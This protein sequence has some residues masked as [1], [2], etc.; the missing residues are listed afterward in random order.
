MAYSQA[1]LDALETAI[2][3]GVLTL[4][5]GGRSVTYQSLSEMRE[6]AAEM[7]RSLNI[8]ART[9]RLAATSKGV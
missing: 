1:Q 7:R 6:L 5:Y 9:Y 8:A 4:S 3:L 2:A